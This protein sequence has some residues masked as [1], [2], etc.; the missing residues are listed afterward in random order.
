MDI[1]DHIKQLDKDHG[2]KLQDLCIN[3]NNYETILE[4]YFGNPS[5]IG[6]HD[7]E[8]SNTYRDKLAHFL[9]HRSIDFD[10]Y[11][12]YLVNFLNE[13]QSYNLQPDSDGNYHIDHRLR[14][15]KT[16]SKNTFI[17]RTELESQIIQITFN[18]TQA[19]NKK[20]SAIQW[21]INKVLIT[22]NNFT[23][24]TKKYSNGTYLNRVFSKITPYIL[25]IIFFLIIIFSIFT[26]NIISL[27]NEL[28]SI[29][30]YPK[31]ATI[32]VIFSSIVVV[33]PI[34]NIIK[35]LRI[36]SKSVLSFRINKRYSNTEKYI[37]SF[38]IEKR[39]S[40]PLFENRER[41]IST[42]NEDFLGFNLLS[43]SFYYNSIKDSFDPNIN[44]ISIINAKKGMGKTSFLNL[45]LCRINGFTYRHE[46]NCQLFKDVLTNRQIKIVQ[47]SIM[48]FLASLNNNDNEQ[49]YI[50]KFVSYIADNLAPLS[51]KYLK[52]ILSSTTAFNNKFNL[53]KFIDHFADD[54]VLAKVKNDI[55]LSEQKNL[56]IIE[57]LDRLNEE[58]LKIVIN[59]LWF[60]HDLPFTIT[61]LPAEEEKI[62]KAVNLSNNADGYHEE[63]E[64]Y[65]LFQFPFD[66]KN[67][68]YKFLANYTIRL[69]DNTIKKWQINGELIQIKQLY[70][71]TTSPD[72]VQ[73]DW[74]S[75]LHKN[76]LIKNHINTSM[77][78][79]KNI[80]DSIKSEL[81]GVFEKYNISI[82]EFKTI[83]DE[84]YIG[85]SSLFAVQQILLYMIYYRYKY[86][87]GIIEYL[88]RYD[89]WGDFRK[90]HSLNLY[91]ERFLK[92]RLDN[93]A[94]NLREMILDLERFPLLNIN[95]GIMSFTNSLFGFI[96]RSNRQNSIKLNLNRSAN[97]FHSEF[98]TVFLTNSKGWQ[99]LYDNL[100]LNWHDNFD[101]LEIE[102]N[103]EFIL[104]FNEMAETTVSTNTTN[105]KFSYNLFL[106]QN[107]AIFLL[108]MIR[109]NKNNTLTML[110]NYF[111][112]DKLYN[113]RIKIYNEFYG[114]TVSFEIDVMINYFRRLF[115]ID[116]NN[117]EYDQTYKTLQNNYSEL[118][119]KLI[120]DKTDPKFREV[121]TKIFKEN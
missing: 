82:R 46:N 10:Q 57:D 87:D 93:F 101:K 14:I 23:V 103:D 77:Q 110:E 104:A 16:L 36:Y 97:I 117:F 67:Y 69:F 59:G 80:A 60:I 118:K 40:V 55:K 61:L 119:N 4:F 70:D 2:N 76:N 81:L 95:D 64:E 65:K 41:P 99:S 66:L 5:Q 38:D 94:S 56:I 73:N 102:C 105:H 92:N 18:I 100:S 22:L 27:T 1:I 52:A 20:N 63:H 88:N 47:F 120:S 58:Q 43:A 112:G 48:P 34:Y 31:I 33:S 113:H 37:N 7:F 6:R 106:Y 96:N 54:N 111:D 39:Q 21:K 42:P 91:Q 26:K 44:L 9:Y 11:V 107:F 86:H 62:K 50:R 68:F 25:F 75:H 30:L 32:I 79:N 53:E 85:N 116:H 51:S 90:N 109:Q 13:L 49:I 72:N 114:A 83:V 24:I 8:I 19:P 3:S 84:L 115:N 12:I 74:V 15:S 28:F 108:S 45:L 98:I 35:A 78:F 71:N 89:T 121:F 17:Y 29:N